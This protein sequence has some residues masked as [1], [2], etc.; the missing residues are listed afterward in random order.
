M[1]NCAGGS[2]YDLAPTYQYLI[3]AANRDDLRRPPRDLHLP[4][5][6]R[7]PRSSLGPTY[8]RPHGQNPVDRFAL[9]PTH[10]GTLNRFLEVKPRVYLAADR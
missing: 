6:Y 9:G 7:R 10:G 2:T 8:R 5:T 4:A 1:N 3:K